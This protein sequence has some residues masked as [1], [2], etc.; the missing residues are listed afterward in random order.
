[1]IQSVTSENIMQPFQHEMF[2]IVEQL[3]PKAASSTTGSSLANLFGSDDAASSG[4]KGLSTE[5]SLAVVINSIFRGVESLVTSLTSLFL[6]TIT[7]LVGGK[8]G[9]ASGSSA[10]G[11]A[12]SGGSSATGSTQQGIV[13]GS[14]PDPVL[15][16]LNSFGELVSDIFGEKSKFAGK[17]NGL[18]KNIS[19]KYETLSGTTKEILS[20]VM[21]GAS[22]IFDYVGGPIK[23]LFKKGASLLG[24]IF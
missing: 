11:S 1:M 7:T 3:I 21:G 15:G 14:T 17:V 9:T 23:G 6:K 4:T 19:E 5:T 10:A 13:A 18:I 12:A 24:K 22:S 16:T 20:K 8:Q 2:P